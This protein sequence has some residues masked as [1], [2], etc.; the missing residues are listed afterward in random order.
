MLHADG[1]AAHLVEKLGLDQAAAARLARIAV[2][3]R[4]E[5]DAHSA[6]GACETAAALS[7]I[8]DVVGTTGE[9]SALGSTDLAA[10]SGE[11]MVES[12]SR[13]SI[14]R[15]HRVTVT[16]HGEPQPEE[17]AAALRARLATPRVQFNDRPVTRATVEAD[18]DACRVVLEA[19]VATSELQDDRD[20]EDILVRGLK[21]DAAVQAWTHNARRLSEA[22][23]STLCDISLAE[24]ASGLALSSRTTTI[25]VCAEPLGMEVQAEGARIEPPAPL[26]PSAASEFAVTV[27]LSGRGHPNET[28]LRLREA[29]DALRSEGP[30]PEI[31]TYPTIRAGGGQRA[32]VLFRVRPEGATFPRCNDDLLNALI[33]GVQEVAST[34][35]R[36]ASLPSERITAA[37]WPL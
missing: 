4:H 37:A 15:Q 36:T 27:T 28:A 26:R 8:D 2:A 13:E 7:S 23:V 34:C 5:V 29:Q 22:A 10:I 24:D 32:S 3:R 21:G 9:A 30:T 12:G 16:F 35:E 19:V 6:L 25:S 14:P 17:L 33:V 31:P 18:G 20:A 1:I 11:F